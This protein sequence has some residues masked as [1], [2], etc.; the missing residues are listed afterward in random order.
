MKCLLAGNVA[1]LLLTS[2]AGSK[3]PVSHPEP[4]QREIAAPVESA[5]RP[6]P[7]SMRALAHSIDALASGL[8]DNRQKSLAAA[9]I[10][11]RA[12]NAATEIQETADDARLTSSDVIVALK[13]ALSRVGDEINASANKK[14]HAAFVHASSAVEQLSNDKS[15]DDQRPEIL[16]AFRKVAI[17]VFAAG[18]YAVDNYAVRYEATAREA[19]A[20]NDA[21]A[22]ADVEAAKLATATR[23]TD[24]RVKAAATLDS[25]ADYLATVP[26][27]AE[28]ADALEAAARTVRYSAARLRHADE[29][30]FRLSGWTRDALVASAQALAASAGELELSAPMV[31]RARQSS[32]AIQLQRSFVF[33]R[34]AIQDAIRA[35]VD[36]C[37]TSV[38]AAR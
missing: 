2:C 29:I 30:E 12:A 3:E 1:L 37:R 16:D 19:R 26:A 15:I 20:A 31:E 24:V 21:L 8:E 23:W 25:L 38:I 28:N 17:A 11:L 32:E 34:A 14:A 18:D 4:V 22:K 33:Q 36:T 6:V 7:E 9:L 5:P 13:D 10:A 27:T 35:V